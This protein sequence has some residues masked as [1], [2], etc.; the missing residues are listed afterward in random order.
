[1]FWAPTTFKDWAWLFWK[2]LTDPAPRPVPLPAHNVR[3]T[4]PHCGRAY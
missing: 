2:M 1:M 3:I 4:C